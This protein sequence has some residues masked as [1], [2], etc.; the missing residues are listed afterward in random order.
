[1]K[2]ILLATLLGLSLSSIAYAQTNDQTMLQKVKKA[3]P[4]MN[5]TKITFIPEIKLYELRTQNSNGLSFTNENLDY[6]I[7]N[8]QLIDPKTKKNMTIERDMNLVKDIFK[9]LPYNKSIPVKF[10]NGQRKI[11]VFTDPDCPFC[12]TTDKNIH[13]HLSKDNITFFYFMNPLDIPGH[14]NAP[15]KARKIWC[16]PN[17]TE[18]WKNFMLNDV[19]PENNG[20]CPNPVAETKAL[21]TTLQFNSTPTFIF[22]NGYIWRGGINPDQIREVLNKKAP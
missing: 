6:F 20:S 14:E 9:G 8:G 19:L 2:K 11:A 13:E 12:K 5:V 16:S 17:K 22:D 18:A 10:G 4:K 1:M 21:S 15:L 3:Y 7:L